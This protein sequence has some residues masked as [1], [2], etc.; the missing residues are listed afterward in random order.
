MATKALARP[1]QLRLVRKGARVIARWD[2]PWPCRIDA[3]SDVDGSLRTER[4][5]F[6]FL[7]I[8]EHCPTPKPQ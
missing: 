3:A 6:V 2:C 1:L 7:R 5:V 8:I 4:G